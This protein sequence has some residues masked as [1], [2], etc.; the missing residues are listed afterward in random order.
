M[1]FSIIWSLTRKDLRIV[2]RSRGMRYPLIFIP[3]LVLVVFPLSITLTAYDHG[4]ASAVMRFLDGLIAHMPQGMR[5]SLEARGSVDEQLILLANVYFMAP[6]YLLVPL[7]A[8][9]V[10]A[11]DTFAGEKERGTLEALLYS[12]LTDHE[13]LAGKLIAAWIPAVAV[14]VAGFAAYGVLL[15]V[16]AWP[17]MG[18]IFY[19]TPMWI[20]LVFWVGPGIAGLGIGAMVLVSARVGTLQEATQV[21]GAVVLP[22]ALLIAGQASG[23]LFFSTTAVAVLGLLIWLI[24][25]GLLRIVMRRF[26]RETL[27]VSG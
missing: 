5:A 14:G 21:G 3:L 13:L 12:P 2:L 16:V 1:N 18:E 15:N 8:A 9:T 23:V 22:V 6:L 26:R 24:T 7:L 4:T 27:L 25:A 10:I 11:A 17:V 20:L 19:P